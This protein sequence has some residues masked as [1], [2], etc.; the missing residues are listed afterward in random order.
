MKLRAIGLGH[1][2]AGLE[3][4]SFRIGTLELQDCNIELQNWARAAG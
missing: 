4:K 1:R 3:H 2:A